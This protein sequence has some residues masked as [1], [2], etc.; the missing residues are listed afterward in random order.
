MLENVLERGVEDIRSQM[1]LIS[2]S[3]SQ[4]EEHILDKIAEQIGIQS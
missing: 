3:L 2:E 4:F 1:D